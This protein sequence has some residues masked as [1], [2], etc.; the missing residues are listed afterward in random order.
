MRASIGAIPGLRLDRRIPALA[1]KLRY[2]RVMSIYAV[3][4][5]TY[6]VLSFLVFPIVAKAYGPEALGHYSIAQT[7][8]SLVTPFLATGAE[9]IAIRDLV[10]SGKERGKVAGSAALLLGLFTLPAVLL[11][12][13]AAYAAYGDDPVTVTLVVW[14]AVA[15]LPTPLYVI[16]FLWKAELRPAY[17]VVPRLVVMLVSLGAKAAAA[18]LGYSII[19]IGA[20]TAA[21]AWISALLLTVVFL[22]T[23]KRGERWSLD[24]EAFGSLFAQTLPAMIAM[25]AVLVFFRITHLM[26][27]WLSNY[28]EVGIYAV[29]FQLIQV[30]NI[31]PTIVL[32]TCYPRLVALRD[33]NPRLYAEYL[34]RLLSFFSFAG[35]GLVFVVLVG[36]D[37]GMNLLFGAKFQGSGLTLLLLSISTL[38]N[39]SAAVRG[40]LIFIAN[41]P[42]LHVAN[43]LIGL[44]TLLPANFALIPHYGAQ[45][46]AAAVTIASLV[47]GVLTSFLF[48]E[49]SRFGRRQL[50]R[51]VLPSPQFWRLAT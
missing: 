40:Q 19:A 38:C 1:P 42:N 27:G 23:R 32:T 41:R 16:D 45:G 24:R 18:S 46:G 4:R 22:F 8:V 13:G 37:W 47:S 31:L 34:D 33:E 29:A 50:W 48:S 10:R 5:F 36:G 6:L 49:T 17:S 14:L 21:E 3:E 35:W 12:I 51:L 20:I 26:L 7:V 39:F 28:R 11:P 44:A 43:A 15:F 25:L 2:F 30:P 9:A